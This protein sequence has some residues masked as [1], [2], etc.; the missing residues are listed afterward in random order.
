MSNDTIITRLIG[1]TL[2]GL[3]VLVTMTACWL[4]LQEVAVPDP[5][6]R[7]VTFLLGALVG[8]LTNK[9]N[10]EPVLTEVTNTGT[11]PVPVQDL[12]T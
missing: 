12:G 9:T 11:D 2:C 5:L 3:A 4:F 7:L 1:F 6:D 10:D 8:R